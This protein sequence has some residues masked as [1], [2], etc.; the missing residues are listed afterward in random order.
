MDSLWLA[1]AASMFVAAAADDAQL[2]EEFKAVVPNQAELE[3]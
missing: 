2:L 3:G 1:L